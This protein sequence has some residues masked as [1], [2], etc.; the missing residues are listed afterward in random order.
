MAKY[1][2]SYLNRDYNEDVLNSWGS[3]GLTETAKRLGYRFVLTSSTVTSGRTPSVS[4]SLRNDGFSAPYNSRPVQLVL[5]DGRRRIT[6]PVKADADTWQPGRTITVGASLARVPAGHWSV[7][8]ALPAPERSLAHDVDYAIQTA[9]VGT[10][11]A[12]AGVNRLHQTV[13]VG[14]R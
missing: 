8:L 13:T 11:D 5:T 6:V 4:V 3:A 9:N 2:Y 7:A 1:H 10:W 12:R 14:R